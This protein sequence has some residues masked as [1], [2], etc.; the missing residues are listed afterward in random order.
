MWY[1]CVCLASETLTEEEKRSEIEKI[2]QLK[3]TERMEALRRKQME[4]YTKMRREMRR[5]MHNNSASAALSGGNDVKTSALTFEP[6]EPAATNVSVSIFVSL[7]SLFAVYSGGDQ[8]SYHS[9]SQAPHCESR[10]PRCH[11]HCYGCSWCC[12]S[13]QTR[14]C[15]SSLSHARRWRAQ[16]CG[17]SSQLYAVQ[18]R[19]EPERSAGRVRY[20]YG[21]DLWCSQG[22]V[23][24]CMRGVVINTVIYH[25]E[26]Q[27]KASV[28][29]SPL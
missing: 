12:G 25:R 21:G 8:A 29:S 19:I 7:L 2:N 20:G 3:E 11:C 10:S 14:L 9:G 13:S 22:S 16:A 23:D 27:R 28:V 6:L 26:K 15:S 4:G 17:Q 1:C 5:R 18:G 24:N